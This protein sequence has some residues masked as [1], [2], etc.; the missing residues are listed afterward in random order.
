ML[1]QPKTY[2]ANED[3]NTFF[4]ASSYRDTY[5]NWMSQ[6]LTHIPSKTLFQAES[7]ISTQPLESFENQVVLK[8]EYESQFRLNTFIHDEGLYLIR[9]RYLSLTTSIKPIQ[10]RLF[11]NG[12]IPYDEASRFRLP[13]LW[14]QNDTLSQDRF[15]NDIV[16][17]S[18]QVYQPLDFLL[19]DNVG[20]YG[21]PLYIYLH[22]GVNTLTFDLIDGEVYIF[23]VGFE[24]LDLIPA[25]ENPI[26]PTGNTKKIIIE[27]E[28]FSLKT[29][30]S[31]RGGSHRDPYVTPFSLMETRI[32]ILDGQTFSR[33]RQSVYYEIEV[34]TEGYYYITLKTLQN[35]AVN[36]SVF[37]DITI[38][39]AY[40]FKES[41]AI[42][43]PYHRQFTHQTLGHNDTYFQ[44]Y[45]PEGKHELGIHTNVSM[46][47][48][49]YIDTL[50]IMARINA[51]TL[52]IQ[53]ITGNQL[54][55]NRDWNI[56]DYLPNLITTL[57][58]LSHDIQSLYLNWTSIHSEATSPT[59]TALKLSHQ[60]IVE[61][62]KEPNEIPK[63]LND[64]S[65]GSGSVLALIG[66]ILPQ[67][68]TAPLS[69]DTI[70]IHQD[71][72]D[73]P[74]VRAPFFTRLWVN[75]QRFFLSFFSDQ[76]DDQ[77]EA[78]ELEVWVNRGRAYVDLMQ[79]MADTL[80]TP[81]SHQKVR[82]S[83]MPDENKL[84]LAN[85]ADAQPDIAVG[86]A[87]WRPFEFA[88][89][90]S[91]HDLRTYDDF[92]EVASR[93]E[94]GSFTGLIYQEGVYA[95]P[96]TQNFQLLF[97][98]KDVL[99][100]LNLEVPNTWTDVITMLPEL[101]RFGL[102]F[103]I[104]LANNAAF[105]SFDTTFPWIVQ[106][107][108]KLY[109]DDG[110]SVAYDDP[111]TLQAIKTMTDLFKIY[112]LPVEV[113]S[114]Y[115]RFRYGDLPIGVGDFGMY[116]Q[117]L[118]AAPEISGLWDI[119]LIPGVYDETQGIVNR[120]FV[121]ASTVNVIFEASQLKDE[122]WNFLKWWSDAETQ[123]IYS[124]RLITTYGPEFLWN[125]ANKEAF[126]NMSWDRNHQAIILE[127]W[128]F[129]YDPIKVPGSYMVERE[130]SNIWNKVVYDG[131]NIRTAVEDSTVIV[132]REITRKMT[133]FG[134]LNNDGV[135]VKNYFI[136][137][138]QT[139]I[140]WGNLHDNTNR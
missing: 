28:D 60:R 99:N 57:N 86:I 140:E 70:Y 30:P 119:A 17:E 46:Y 36:T 74:E 109:A 13:T 102:N 20:L 95:L 7:L 111:K 35:A 117:L 124:E 136:P 85:A 47:E 131:V 98:R 69:I 123:V 87:A 39:G 19:E 38:N 9:L 96:D 80:Y 63:N 11:V 81:D 64:L 72:A 138:N 121:G 22:Q 125:T 129:V 76:Y 116:V 50:E 33:G 14:S 41:K 6:G 79:Q 75:I 94:S 49:L 113:G 135:I 132:N 114:F 27:G 37:R 126:K 71:I 67:L 4:M 48:D 51:L 8:W 106:H 82:I 120:S 65:I 23:E 66:T 2:G 15:G 115:Q 43:F 130:L 91:L 53:K 25:Y 101:Q 3:I 61:L 29:D 83:I 12:E 58:D 44:F 16:P 59:T 77:A 92:Y 105:K 122:A 18:Y 84:I 139:I 127:Q 137:T 10:F 52:D 110:F 133:E 56:S 78:D 112:S 73:L 128:Q 104:P 21:E 54:D 93:Y 68:I 134:Y 100:N 107:G 32:N 42:E 62:A 89:R 88:I 40:P 108:G 31:I 1:P 97:Y 55:E 26:N 103:Y 5:Q 90:G 118:N 45:L 34:A 24:T